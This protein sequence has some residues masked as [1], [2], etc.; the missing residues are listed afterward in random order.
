MYI[1]G[2]FLAN[3][4]S[5]A[6]GQ[7]PEAYTATVS[8][9][10]SGAIYAIYGAFLYI[11]VLQ[12]GMMDEGSRKTLYGLLVMGIVMSFVTPYVNWIAHLGGLAAGFFL[13]G[14]I[15]RLLKRRRR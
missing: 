12:R 14:L 13:Y 7:T 4:L 10:A 11:A 15:I 8:V 1:M 6:L 9:G 5:V 3:V 2:G